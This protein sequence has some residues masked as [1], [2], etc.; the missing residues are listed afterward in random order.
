MLQ[1]ATPASVEG[2]FSVG[3]VKLRGLTYRLRVRGGAYYITESYLT[4]TEQEHRVDYTL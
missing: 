1:R 2:D 4:G 3:E